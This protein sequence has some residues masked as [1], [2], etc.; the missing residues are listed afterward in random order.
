MITIYSAEQHVSTTTATYTAQTKKKADDISRS[1]NSTNTISMSVHTT[2]D[3]RVR[4]DN[5]RNTSS[6]KSNIEEQDFIT[7]FLIEAS[8]EMNNVLIISNFSKSQS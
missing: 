2:I 4:T 7:E 6:R 8:V 5:A 3:A 1:Q